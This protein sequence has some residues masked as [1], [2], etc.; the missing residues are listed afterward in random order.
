MPT[1]NPDL[2]PCINPGSLFSR[3]TTDPSINI[4]WFVPVDPVTNTVLNRPI[5]DIA[6]R[7]LILAK[8][9][10][11][12]NLRLGH[13][14]LFPFLVTA[15]VN[16]GTQNV[17]IPPSW[18]WDMQASLPQKW[19]RVRLARVK[20]L[21]GANVDSENEEHTGIIRLVFTAEEQGS[22]TEVALFQAD[23]RIDSPLTY[24]I[25]RII[26]PSPGDEPLVIPPGETETVGGFITF[27]T[28]DSS[29]AG[30]QAFYS[31][32]APPA[33]PTAVDSNGFFLD[34]LVI[35]V[36]DSVPGGSGVTGDFDFTAVS[37]GTGLLTLSAW[38]P[39]PSVDS[40][41][42]TWLNTFRYPFDSG[43]SLQ[44]SNAVGVVIPSGLFKEFN[45]V[46]PAGD[47]PDGDLS[48]EFFPVYINRI[49]RLDPTSDTLKFFF[50][51]F[52]VEV[53][54]IVPVEFASLTLERTATEGSVVV[55]VPEKDLFQVQEGP[56]WMQGFG[57]GHVSLSNLWGSTSTTV[58]DFFDSFQ[59]IID[60]TPQA[61][62]TKEATR[63][64]SFGISRVPKYTPTTGQSQALKGTRNGISVPGLTN[65]YVVELDQ[66]LGD[67][68]DFATSTELPEDR[69]ENPDIERFGFT[70]ALTHRT[71][72][73]IMNTDGDEHDYETD[74]LPRLRILFGRDPDFGDFWWDGTVLKFFNGDTW[75][76]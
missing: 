54:S 29:D 27:R 33:D 69:R 50:S 59:T 64:S 75:I 12:L 61:V 48:G 47:E 53:P 13:Q 19:E 74:V 56:E 6:L 24:Q 15:Q 7:Q 46:A 42:S 10:D 25:I 14:A 4:R 28:L 36:N 30:V 68:V 45:I 38:N 65:R 9:I 11:A 2:V 40:T 71:V 72:F 63:I 34:P 31:V 76:G 60:A 43:A 3:F 16:S 22:T 18:M 49:E 32:V 37:H 20:R 66:G 39:I 70:G 5:G 73:M 35:D 67:Q 62:F 21:S 23:F 26:T 57:K 8:T 17:D 44:A 51:T 41:I 52:N 1:L 58:D 55:I